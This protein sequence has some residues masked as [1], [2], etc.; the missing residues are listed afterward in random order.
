MEENQN[1]FLSITLPQWYLETYPSIEKNLDSNQN[2]I[3][4]HLDVRETMLDIMGN[5]NVRQPLPNV[6]DPQFI[7]WMKGMK[8]YPGKSLLSR[9][10]LNRSCADAGI[11]PTFTC[12]MRPTLRAPS[13]D[14]KFQPWFASKLGSAIEAF[15]RGMVK[16]YFPVCKKFRF[17]SVVDAKASETPLNENIPNGWDV[18]F[19]Y[20]IKF[21][22]HEFSPN[23]GKRFFGASFLSNI[24]PIE[25]T[26]P[27]SPEKREVN[28]RFQLIN[29][30]Q[31]TRWG[32]N[33]KCMP[34]NIPRNIQTFCQCL[35][36]STPN[37]VHT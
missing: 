4:T 8:G 34:P 30:D 3:V 12:F 15:L 35:D 1:P 19:E 32:P 16:K 6:S 31:F 36:D 5:S 28:D 10:D 24:G 17:H 29:M 22:V 33:K 25:A 27:Q 2:N 23:A 14:R 20:N 26:K 9:I 37:A 7:G 21:H 18:A 11:D 13:L